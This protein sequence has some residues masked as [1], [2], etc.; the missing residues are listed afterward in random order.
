[1]KRLCLIIIC[2]TSF[3]ASYA[4]SGDIYSEFSIGVGAGTT[5]V[6][7]YVLAAQNKYALNGTFS[8]NITPF[9]ALTGEGQFGKFEGGDLTAFNMKYFYS[10]YAAATLHA[11]LQVGELIDYDRSDFLYSLKDAYFGSGFGLLKNSITYVQPI[12]PNSNTLYNTVTSSTNFLMPFVFGYDFKIYNAYDEPKIRL[13][14][15]YTLNAVFGQGID[16]YV[17]AAPVKFYTYFS[18]GV[19]YGFGGGK[20]YRKPIRY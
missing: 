7:D 10:A 8:Y 4:Q 11:D 13:D 20:L 19:K 9:F 1:M 15:S 18:V 5:T 6:Y 17:T 12:S 16:G 2:L 14:V 3:A